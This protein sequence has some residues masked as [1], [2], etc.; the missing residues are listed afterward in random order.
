MPFHRVLRSSQ[1]GHAL[2]AFGLGIPDF[3]KNGRF[4]VS[5]IYRRKK[6]HADA[7]SVIEAFGKYPQLPVT[8][9]GSL[10]SNVSGKSYERIIIG[11][12]C[13]DFTGIGENGLIGTV[14]TA[15]VNEAEKAIYLAV[16]TPENRN[17]VLTQPM[18]DE[19]LTD[20]K[21]HPEAFFG[22]IQHVGQENRRTVRTVL[23]FYRELQEH[24]KRQAI[25]A[26]ERCA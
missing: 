3:G 26:Y 5:E 9:D 10:P 19:A 18:S 13:A 2:M 16:S 24:A 7:F 21:A 8:F 17:Y 12:T 4:K 6:K 22:V 1:T 25:G 14:T 20:Y 23:I 11:E 15:M